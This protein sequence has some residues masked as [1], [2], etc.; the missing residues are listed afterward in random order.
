M[1]LVAGYVLF[2]VAAHEFGH[3]LGLSH[4]DDPGAL[5]YPLYTYRNPDTF[6][7][8]RDDVNGV[9]SLYG[10]FTQKD[11]CRIF[12]PAVLLQ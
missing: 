3:S 4:S 2:M 11:S 8:P 7:L 10:E 1:L 6:V 12:L 9:Q 5:M